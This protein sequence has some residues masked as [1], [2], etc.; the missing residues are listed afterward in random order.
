MTPTIKACKEYILKKVEH[1]NREFDRVKKEVSAS[2][3]LHALKWTCNSVVS[4]GAQY[5]SR[6]LERA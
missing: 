5:L 4:A 1:R 2:C 3:R 6:L